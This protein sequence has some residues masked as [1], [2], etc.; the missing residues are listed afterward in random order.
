MVSLGGRTCFVCEVWYSGHADPSS[1]SPLANWTDRN[2]YDYGGTCA[3]FYT[4]D[5]VGTS[6]VTAGYTAAADDVVLLAIAVGEVQSVSD[7]I[8]SGPML[9]NGGS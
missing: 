4:F 7:T 5:V 6:D 9:F 1:V 2:Q 8:L 3:G